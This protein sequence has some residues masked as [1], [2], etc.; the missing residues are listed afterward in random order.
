MLLGCCSLYSTI[1][2][3]VCFQSV[4]C[5]R[6][7]HATHALKVTLNWSTYVKNIEDV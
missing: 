7:R 3:K 6:F 2:K 1:H 4:I 5:D